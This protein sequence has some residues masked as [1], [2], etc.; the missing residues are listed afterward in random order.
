MKLSLQV[1]APAKAAG[2]TIPITLSPFVIGRD[3][4]CNLRPASPLV[5]KRHCQLVIRA[6]KV[7]VHD[8]DSTNGTFVNERQIKGE[9]EI[10]DKDILKVGPLDFKVVIEASV[11]PSKPTPL[12]PSKATEET[13][14]EA[15]AALLM[16]GND[17]PR[18]TDV[19]DQGVPTGTTEMDLSNPPE[20]RP[21]HEASPKAEQKPQP[22]PA[23]GDTSAAAKSL[24]DKYLR[25]R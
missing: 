12:P 6:G 11:P 9:I 1:L 2:T 4:G 3:S 22:K 24:L 13:A 18:E 20:T 15:A 10:L 17:A 19:D 7:F 8:F 14:D 21:D 5:S 16:E 23:S 25:R